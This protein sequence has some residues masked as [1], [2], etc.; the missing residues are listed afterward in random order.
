ML[1]RRSEIEIKVQAIENV[2]SHDSNKQAKSQKP[3]HSLLLLPIVIKQS[4]YIFERI[5][6]TITTHNHPNV[7]LHFS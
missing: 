7:S 6:K 5:V 4:N 2:G 3:S 1:T